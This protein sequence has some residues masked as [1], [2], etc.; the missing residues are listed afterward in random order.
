MR[1]PVLFAACLLLAGC[2]DASP[3]HPASATS[4]EHPADATLPRPDLKVPTALPEVNLGRADIGSEPNIAVAPDGT[5]YI[6][7]PL[8]LWRSTDGGKTYQ[9]MGEPA[10]PVFQ[11]QAPQCVPALE[12]RNPGLDGGGDGDIA[13]D[14]QGTVHWI[15]LAGSSGPIPYQS[16]HDRAETFGRPI[17]ISNG[18]GSDRQWITITPDDHV[19]AGWRDNKD[20]YVIN[21]SMDGGATW[22]GKVKVHDDALAG[23]IVFDPSW[24]SRL[25]I[26]WVT[27]NTLSE[28]GPLIQLARS[29]DDG[30]T[31][32]VLDV[33]TVPGSPSDLLSATSIFPVAAVDD[34]GTVYV[35][36]SERQLDVPAPKPASQY[37]VVLYASHD[38]G[39][40]WTQGMQ[41]SPPLKVAVFPW[42]AAGAP[43]RIAVTYYENT[44]GL[45]ND[46]LPDLWNTMLVESVDADAAT[47]HFAVVQ[48]NR[49]PNHI[50]SVCTNGS[51]CLLTGG[52]RSLLDFFEVTIPADGQPRVAWSGD[53][54][55]PPYISSTVFGGGA[56]DGTPLR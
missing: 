48:L 43:G 26:P 49:L 7:T 15:G 13:V 52:D 29:E 10:C 12:Q 56:A 32:D 1:I 53:S 8:Q 6:T 47:P 27:S 17:D 20:G 39:K 2:L 45:P 34:A 24:S 51:V 44:V 28:T 3:S 31:W 23:P 9:A 18:T 36:V 42:V 19:F 16:S 21:R 55:T 11:I 25:Y 33:A 38:H 46:N 50:G 30:R 4:V 37:G 41:V 5:L 40:T 14:S 35:V 54:F 22:L